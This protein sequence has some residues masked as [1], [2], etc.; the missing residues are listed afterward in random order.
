[1]QLT[2]DI[3]LQQHQKLLMTPELRQA[4]AI[5]QMSSLELNEY[6]QQEL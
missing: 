2:P 6:V 5:Q 1:M 4:I 3:F